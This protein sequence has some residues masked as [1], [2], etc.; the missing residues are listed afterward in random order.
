MSGIETVKVGGPEG[1]KGLPAIVV[2]SDHGKLAYGKRLP[3][4][5]LEFLKNLIL[6]KIAKRG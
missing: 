1:G 5:T 6:A 4:D 2:V 3:R